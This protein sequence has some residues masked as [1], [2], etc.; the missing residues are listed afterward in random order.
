VVALAYL[1]VNRRSSRA[2]IATDSWLGCRLSRVR[3]QSLVAQNSK[4]VGVSIDPMRTRII[5]M[6]FLATWSPNALSLPG[7]GPTARNVHVQVLEVPM[8]DFVGRPRAGASEPVG[9]GTG[10]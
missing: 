7:A 9:E 8:K 6:E 2:G 3:G 10:R 1:A 4:S 5:L